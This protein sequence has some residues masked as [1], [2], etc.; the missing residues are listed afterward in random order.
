MA[1]N[2]KPEAILHSW[3]TVT[4]YL[5]KANI[6][7]VESLLAYEMDNQKREFIALRL[8]T[9]LYTLKA[10]ESKEALKKELAKKS[11]KKST[12]KRK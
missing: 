1:K 9:R 4:S 8:H 12:K 2:F 3:T 5:T 11:P 10:K 6:K 7:E